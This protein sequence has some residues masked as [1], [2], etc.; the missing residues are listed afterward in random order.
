MELLVKAVLAQHRLS[1]R[2]NKGLFARYASILMGFQD[3]LR[4]RPEADRAN[5]SQQSS[6]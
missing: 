4:Q 1:P 3:Q 2:S 6:D 5:E